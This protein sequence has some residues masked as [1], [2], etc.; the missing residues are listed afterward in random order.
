VVINYS[1]FHLTSYENCAFLWYRIL[2]ETA[3]DAM[4]KHS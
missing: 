4:A 3:N 2:N 1:L